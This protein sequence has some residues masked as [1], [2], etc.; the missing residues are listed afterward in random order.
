M[1]AFDELKKEVQKF[2]DQGYDFDTAFSTAFY[3]L[4]ERIVEYEAFANQAD[5]M[6][7]LK[8]KIIVEINNIW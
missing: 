4:R 5:E 3:V 2:I 1:A 6:L 8:H 7:K